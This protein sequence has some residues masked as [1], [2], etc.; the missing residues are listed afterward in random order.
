M[1]FRAESKSFGDNKEAYES[2][3]RMEEHLAKDNGLRLD[4]LKYQLG[5]KL[6]VDARTEGVVNDEEANKLLTRQYRKGFEV[7]AKV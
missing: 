2:L 6:V 4:G 1:P 5:R 7:P 3:A